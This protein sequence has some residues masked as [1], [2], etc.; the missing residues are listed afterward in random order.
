MAEALSKAA[1]SGL[2]AQTWSSYKTAKN[3]LARCQNE[4]KVL[5]T[6]PLTTEKVLV[7]ISWLLFKRKVKAKSAEVYVSGLRC[8]HL[9]NGHENPML[10]PGIVKLI[11]N[12]QNNLDKLM[13]KIENKSNRVAVTI[14]ILKLIKKKL[15]KSNLDNVR[16]HLIWSTSTLAFCGG[17]RIHELLSRERQSYDPFVTLLGKDLVLKENDKYPHIQILLKTQKKDRIGKNEVV[18]V[19]GTDNFFC[20]IRAYKKYKKSISKLSFTA[21]KPNFRTQDGKTYTGKMFNEDL[22]TLLSSVI[23]Y[24]SMGKVSSHSFRIG[25]TTMLGKL[26]FSDQDI[27]AIGRWPSSAF[28]LYIRS[29]D[30]SELKLRKEWLKH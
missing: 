22:K 12:G 27:M 16:K 7:Y 21:Q 14:P 11:L 26:G 4:T 19:F 10:R 23:D 24:T 8:L 2:S 17:F 18:D 9:I 3:H 28:E 13:E 6:F 15:L 25:I 29:L 30:Q 5:M 1:N 20:P